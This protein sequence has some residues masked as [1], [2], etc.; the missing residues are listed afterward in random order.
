MSIDADRYGDPYTR[1][2]SPTGHDTVRPS[3]PLGG[4]DSSQAAARL[5]EMTA[6]ETEQWRTDARSE[7]A[8]IVAEA[9]QESAAL[10]QA[11]REEAERLVTSARDEAAKTTNDARVE[12]GRVREETIAY[13]S[14]HDEEIARLQQVATEHRQ[15]LRNH[16]TEMLDQVDSTPGVTER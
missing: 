6:N 2:G 11:A 14:S 9:H 5:L 4:S 3:A 8:A 1:T 13:R 15:R 12:A 7:A 16:L 10:G